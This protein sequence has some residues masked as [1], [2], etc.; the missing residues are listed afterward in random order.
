MAA[1]GLVPELTVEAAKMAA[2]AP[3]PGWSGLWLRVNTGGYGL[4]SLLRTF[5]FGRRDGRTET[6]YNAPIGESRLEAPVIIAGNKTRLRKPGICC[7]R[8]E[9]LVTGCLM[10]FRNWAD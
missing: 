5:P 4:S 1:V 3:E 7:A 8:P 6:I 9:N 10:S 2:R